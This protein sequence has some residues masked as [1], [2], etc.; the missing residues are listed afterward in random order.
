MLER[1]GL[2]DVVVR[3]LGLICH[4]PD[5]TEWATMVHRAKHPKGTVKIALVGKYVALHDAYLSVVEALTH[6]GIENDVKVEVLWVDSETVTDENAAQVLTEADGV[7]VPG[8]FGDRGIEGKISA[9][10]YAREHKVPFL[11][12]CLGMQMAVVEYARHVCGWADAHSSE[13]DPATTHPVIDLMPDQRGV[14]AKGGTMRLGSYPCRVTS[15]ETR[16]YRAYGD[17][18]IAERHRHRYEFNNDYRQDLTGAGLVLA[19]LSPDERLVEIVELKD[20]PWFVGVQFHPELKSRP[21]K[22]HPL[23]RDF[24]AAAKAGQRAEA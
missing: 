14:T 23:F 19:G 2:A 15:R 22:A 18:Q 20:H 24:I 11:G 1:E 10:R 4:A 9:V 12:I 21:N 5:L 16:T 8:G 7:L 6:G 3:R 13:L 17:D